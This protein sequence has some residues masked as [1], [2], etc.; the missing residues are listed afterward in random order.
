MSGEL[1]FVAPQI[2][3]VVRPPLALEKREQRSG[4]QAQLVLPVSLQLGPLLRDE[5]EARLR[6]AVAC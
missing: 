5:R 1:R 3:G 2:S 4:Q 6:R